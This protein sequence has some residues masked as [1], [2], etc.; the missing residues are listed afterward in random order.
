MSTQIKN[1][2]FRFVTMRAPELA[3]KSISKGSLVRLQDY[4]FND[5]FFAN[6]LKDTGISKPEQLEK[7]KQRATKFPYPLISNTELEI[8]IDSEFFN[9]STWISKKGKSILSNKTLKAEFDNKISTAKSLDRDIV[10]ELWNN[11]FYL[12]IT[13]KTPSLRNEIMRVLIANNHLDRKQGEDLKNYLDAK[14]LI[15]STFFGSVTVE[16]QKLQQKDEVAILSGFEMHEEMDLAIALQQKKQF[17]KAVTEL[18]KAKKEYDKRN[19]KEL[20]ASKKRHDTTVNGILK[21]IKKIEKTKTDCQTGCTETYYEYEEVTLPEFEYNPPA[22]IDQNALIKFLSQETNY[23]L[24]S[25]NLYKKETFSEIIEDL[26]DEIASKDNSLFKSAALN[27][28]TVTLMGKTFSAR[29]PKVTVN[30]FSFRCCPVQVSSTKFKVNMVI[31]VPDASVNVSNMIYHMHYNGGATNTNGTFQFSKSGNTITLS[32]LYYGNNASTNTGINYLSGNNTT[33][34]F[35]GIITFSNGTKMDFDMPFDA[36]ICSLGYLMLTPIENDPIENPEDETQV[37]YTFGAKRIGIADYRKVEQEVCCYVPGEVS[38]IENIM[39]REYKEKSTRM[40]RRSEDTTTTSKEQESEKLTDTS[41]TDRFEMNQET[42]SVIAE[43][44]SM[45]AGTSVS[46]Q[47]GPINITAHADFANNTSQEQSNSQAL[48]TA[49]EITER[50]LDRVVKKVKEERITKII[51]EFEENNKHGFD[52]R[53]GDKNISGVYRWVDKVYNNKIINYG[54]RLMY[55]FMIPEPASFHNLAMQELISST[56]NAV[57]SKPI[58][59]RTAS[60]IGITP[61]KTS[62]EV[63][64]SN[65]QHWA[66][67]YNVE[68]DAHPDELISVGQ[69]FK[70]VYDSTGGKIGY[71]EA[72]AGSGVI[73]IPEGYYAISASGLFNSIGEGSSPKATSLTIGILSNKNL[74]NSTIKQVTVA[75]NLPPY[76]AEVPVSFTLGQDCAGDITASVNCKLTVEAKQKWQNE[77]FNAIMK[78]YNEKLEEYETKKKELEASQVTEI[79]ANPMFYRQIEN[80]V[81]KKNCISYLYENSKLGKN[82]ITGSTLADVRAK[83]DA[84]ALEKYAAEVKFFEQAFEW[85]LISYYFYPFFWGNKSKWESVY[86]IENDDALFRSFLQSGMAKVIAT[87]RPGFEESVM[88]YMATG[89]IW[90]GGEVPA[91][92]DEMYVSI[93]DELRNP[94]GVVEETWESRVPTSLTVIQA[95]SIGLDVQGLPCDT[96]CEDFK[97]ENGNSTNPIKDNGASIGGENG[98]LSD[99]ESQPA[100]VANR[101]IENIDI[102]NGNLQLTTNSK[103]RKVVAQISVEAIKREMKLGQGK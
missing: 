103:P 87:V 13:R 80:T 44:T 43:N 102:K 84:V 95:G 97:D 25:L 40:L 98:P 66:S 79:K 23:V 3:D 99:D 48:T 54:K 34:R 89:E 16:N 22:E 64:L 65:Y 50:A 83:Y 49:K 27:Q 41:T 29:L 69:S 17:E 46:G 19:Q 7:L 2:L 56:E 37:P 58:D 39:A 62:K 100:K 12:L 72:Q 5:G 33:N 18:S 73:K 35:S 71:V 63:T 82:M 8:L 42:A 30:Q 28:K 94:E 36:K 101:Q 52:N 96:E 77:T 45:A 31:T 93:I 4:Y 21:N 14:V 11:L 51:E 57:L 53:K 81:L 15:P 78:A 47:A 85:D 68:V 10:T 32:D 75:G 38:H 55:E 90:N 91:I 60:A 9:F 67:L 86:K 70:V 59:P 76:I 20:D 1:T 74:S 6:E 88:Y 92:D 26:T 61:I 24:E